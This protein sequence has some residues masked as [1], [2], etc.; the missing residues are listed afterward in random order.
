MNS[1]IL[2]STG[3]AD[4]VASANRYLEPYGIRVIGEKYDI[5]EIQSNSPEE[6]ATHKAKQAFE[7]AQKPV[8]VTDAFWEFSALNGFPGAYM[9]YV[10]KWFTAQDFINLMKDH[11]NREVIHTEVLVYVDGATIKTFRHQHTGSVLNQPQGDPYA[12]SVDQVVTFRDGRS[13]AEIRAAG[14]KNFEGN[15]IW[16]EFGEWLVGQNFENI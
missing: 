13:I 7:Y 8:I 14:E 5:I 10:S 4:K 16:V 15:S 12:L 6:I 11:E 1:E 9:S 2:F 3:N